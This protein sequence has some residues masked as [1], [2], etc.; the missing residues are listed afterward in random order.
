[1]SLALMPAMISA[2]SERTRESTEEFASAWTGT[3]TAASKTIEE[4]SLSMESAFPT[5]A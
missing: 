4:Y 5:L 3:H 1:M 2:T